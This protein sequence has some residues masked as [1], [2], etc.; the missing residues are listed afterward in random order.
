MPKPVR[1]ADVALAAERDEFERG[2]M[3]SRRDN[4]TRI[5][6]DLSLTIFA[7][8]QWHYGWCW[9][10]EDGPHFSQSTYRTESDARDALG[11]ELG[12]Y[13]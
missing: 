9:S 2:W 4:L 13:E 11:H 12:V 1:P 8:D 10:D 6:N 7:R 3:R 5:W